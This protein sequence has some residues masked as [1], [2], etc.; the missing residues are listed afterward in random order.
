[1]ILRVVWVLCGLG[2][3]VPAALA[4]GYTTGAVQPSLFNP[5]IDSG[6]FLSQA[7]LG[8]LSTLPATLT[9]GVGLGNSP[10]NTLAGDPVHM[11]TGNLYHTERDIRIKG[12]GGLPLVF[13][14]SY[15]SRA[16]TDGP[17]GYGWTHSFN[18]AFTFSD[19]N[20]NGAADPADSDG[21]T[22]SVTW[23]DGSGAQ[24]FIRVAG[25]A[26]AAT[27]CARRTASPTP[28]SPWRARWGRRPGCSGSPTAP[29]TPSPSTTQ[30]AS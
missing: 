2:G 29:A 16:A 6:Y 30:A 26:M 10:Y 21:I 18:H 15:N 14:R 17:L 19:D 24:R 1:M 13:E 3:V 27:P 5:V 9:S 8:S 22:S 12:R 23:T 25:G 11:V 28:S 7:A 20:A 4:G